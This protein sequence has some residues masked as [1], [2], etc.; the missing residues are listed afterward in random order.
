MRKYQPKRA[1]LIA[2]DVA[3]VVLAILLTAITVGYLSN[4]K[5]IMTLLLCLFWL[6]AILFAAVLLPAY[7]SRTVIYI[8]PAEISMKTGIVY[9][10]RHHMKF[11]AVQYVSTVTTFMS[12]YTGLNF[13]ILR[14]MGGTMILPFL[15]VEDVREIEELMRNS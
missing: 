14:A 9:V 4:Y 8:S 2:I 13:V 15:G 1:A 3:I 11:S 12:K 6:V 10:K 7:F 5:I